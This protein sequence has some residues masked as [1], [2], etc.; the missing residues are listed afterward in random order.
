MTEEI[1]L[2]IKLVLR[3]YAIH[4][5]TKFGGDWTKASKVILIERKRPMLGNLSLKGNN[6]RVTT[7][8]WLVIKLVPE[9]LCQYKF[10]GD[11]TQASKVIEQTRPI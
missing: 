8:I 1:W 2:F 9:I 3:Y 10:G 6:S 5:L 4:I 11:W 7:A